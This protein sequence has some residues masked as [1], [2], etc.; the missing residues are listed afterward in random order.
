MEPTYDPDIDRYV[1]PEP[2]SFDRHKRLL[3]TPRE[4]TR[5]TCQNIRRGT[6][7]IDLYTTVFKEEVRR[8]RPLRATRWMK[9]INLIE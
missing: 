1:L 7:A 9:Y 2:E 4:Q 3:V 5:D 8:M 6:K